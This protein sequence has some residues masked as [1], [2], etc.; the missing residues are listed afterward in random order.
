MKKNAISFTEELGLSAFF[1]VLFNNSEINTWLKQ[2]DFSLP[3]QTKTK[4][5]P[6]IGEILREKGYISNAKIIYNL[7][8]HYN[9]LKFEKTNKMAELIY[10]SDQCDGLFKLLEV[11]S[12]DEYIYLN[13]NEVQVKIGFFVDVERKYSGRPFGKISK[14]VTRDEKAIISKF[15]PLKSAI[16]WVEVSKLMKKQ[17][18]QGTFS[19][20]SYV[21]YKPLK[22]TLKDEKC[23]TEI[24]RN[25]VEFN[26]D[27]INIY[28]ADN[29][30]KIVRY[31]TKYQLTPISSV[32]LAIK[33]ND[34]LLNLIGDPQISYFFEIENYNFNDFAQGYFRE[35]NF[36]NG[37]KIGTA[38]LVKETDYKL[39]DIKEKKVI[40][41]SSLNDLP[42]ESLKN[43]FQLRNQNFLRPPV[44]KSQK[45]D[46]LSQ[47]LKL[48]KNKP[49]DTR[50]YS[51]EIFISMPILFDNPTEE[52]YNE[53]ISYYNS[54]EKKFREYRI[55]FAA[56][57]KSYKEYLVFIENQSFEQVLAEIPNS[58]NFLLFIPPFKEKEFT[59][60]SKSILELGAAKYLKRNI[61]IIYSKGCESF[62]PNID[63][64]HVE[65]RTYNNLDDLISLDLDFFLKT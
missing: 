28:I 7:Y 10:F 36:N 44:I 64:I 52:I 50:M 17:L 54:L 51:Y 34:I 6:I 59:S 58:P 15:Y 31:S 1:D 18:I 13:V 11:K 29:L 22:D 57:G 42:I 8:R 63:S 25:Y 20:Y 62:L 19:I 49:K 56:S 33:T 61:L 53:R 40:S 16:P 39:N 35:V 48:L 26:D 21:E 41:Y 43:Y 37:F 65:K 45:F 9:N 24:L 47:K 23:K 5:C 32:K 4:L 2:Y 30:N 60:V 38:L 3:I 55:Y 27:T 46:D 12:T 14:G